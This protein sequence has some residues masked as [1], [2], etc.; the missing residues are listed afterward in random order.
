MNSFKAKIY[1]IGVNP[2]VLLPTPVLKDIFIQAKRERRA[3]PVRGTLDRHPYIQTLVKY[4]GKWRF[5]FNIPMRKATKKDVGDSVE[6]KIEFD[7]V[8]RTIPIHPKFL[9][10]LNVNKR[11]KKVFESLAPSRQKEIVRYIS[12]LKTEESIDKNVSRATQFLAGKGR[13]VGRDKP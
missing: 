9:E 6:V 2:Y 13:F 7:L 12:F 4:S 1:I 11:A 5:Y 8:E 10:A 3:I